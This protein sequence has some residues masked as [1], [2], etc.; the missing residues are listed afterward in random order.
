MS[1]KAVQK[2]QIALDLGV[3]IQKDIN[4]VEM[5]VLENGIP[6]LTQRGLS[7][8]TGAARSAIQ[9]ITQEWEDHYDDQVIGKDRISYLKAYLFKNG[10]TD[11]KLYIE[12]DKDG[13]RH[14]SYPD[15]VCMA[16]LE[17]YAF[18]SSGNNQTAIESYR[19]FASLGLA[20]FI[21][22]ALGYTPGDKW[23]YH[24]DRVSILNDSAPVGHFTI[25]KEI[26]GMVVDLINA[27]VPVNDKTI[28]DISVGIAW[29]NY[30][31]EN[32]LSQL[33]GERTYYEHNYPGYYP[34]AMS[35][36]QKPA[37]YPDAALP[38][39]RQ[40]FYSEYLPTKFPRY[41]L[42]KAKVLRGGQQEAQ[43]IAGIF[44]SKAI[45]KF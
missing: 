7:R 45:T 12:C 2:G 24:N 33:Y 28:P 38:T 14:Y 5:G 43:A 31:R 4:G 36:P 25:F 37:A 18:E 35:N 19:S 23:K 41:I 9:T 13:S 26:T 29:G 22:K 20:G 30:W 39:F 3:E 11:R 34:Q 44:Q 27:D 16:F 8:I 21:Y 32:D 6:Y 40:W 42:S 10:Y 17:Y 15:I 1:K